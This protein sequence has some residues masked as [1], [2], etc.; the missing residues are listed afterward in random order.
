MNELDRAQGHACSNVC[1]CK[2]EHSLLPLIA[3]ELKKGENRGRKNC[4]VTV[5]CRKRVVPEF[6]TFHF[7]HFSLYLDGTKWVCTARDV[8]GTKTSERNGKMLGMG[9][10]MDFGLRFGKANRTEVRSCFGCSKPNRYWGYRRRFF[11]SSGGAP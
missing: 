9:L 8:P 1:F 7:F 3:T 5:G 6:S 4:Q 11:F 2:A 10:G